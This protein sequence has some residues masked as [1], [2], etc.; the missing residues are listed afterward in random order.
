[1]DAMKFG[2][3]GRPG[4]VAY[5]ADIDGLRALAI[6]P[7]VL[8][9]ADIWPFSGGF[10]GVDVFFVISGHLITS[11]IVTEIEIGEFSLR[12]FYLRRV[13]RIFPALFL[14]LAFCLA[15]GWVLLTPQDYVLLGKSV[16]ATVSFSSNILFWRQSGYFDAPPESWPLLHTW[17]LGVEEQFYVVFPLLLILIHRF[18]PRG[19]IAIIIALGAFSFGLNIF[20]V[21]S[22]P[23]AAFYLLPS[24]VWELLIGALLAMGLFASPSRS[25]ARQISSILGIASIGCAIFGFSKD[26]AFPGFAALLPTI[27]AAAVIWGGSNS[28]AVVNSLLSSR[29]AVLLGKIS[30]S[31]Y[32]WHFP[33]LAFGN[34]V[35]STGLGITERISLLVL[36]VILATGSWLFIEQPVR[37]GYSIFSNS[38][39]VFG[40]ATI[41]LTMFCAFGLVAQRADGFPF[42]MSGSSLRILA[43]ESDFNPDRAICVAFGPDDINRRTPCK[44]GADGAAPEFALWGDSHAESLRSAFEDSAKKARR[45]GIFLGAFGCIPALGI[46]RLD[47]PACRRTNDAIVSYLLSASSIRTVILSGRWA[48]WAEG[49]RYKREA[50]KTVYLSDLT[51]AAEQNHET[52]SI[53]IEQA[54]SVL[55]SAGKQ[56]WLVGPIPEIGYNVPRVLYADQLGISQPLDIRPTQE[57]LK[58]RQDFVFGLLDSLAQKYSLQVVWPH[59]SLCDSALCQVQ[60][61]GVPLYFDDQHLTRSA[62][63]S[64]SQIFDPIFENTYPHRSSRRK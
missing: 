31:L 6:V 50:G 22:Y 56:V 34:Y 8:Y 9:H 46:E 17:S 21:R 57:D 45:T 12:N 53:G 16:V 54:I 37:Q 35:T 28:Q 62:A 55:T 41:T 26:T 19:R 47:V 43:S 10:V 51:G 3:N 44:F 20:A 4:V 63:R 42:R 29:V 15:I 64:I 23:T 13:R 32:L 7:V 11:L 36:S 60:R 14:V 52:V 59:E 49:S 39:W 27:G 48:L 25:S 30:Y 2:Q 33:L 5:R 40:S 38:R 24:R 18:I 58:L 1:V 61:D